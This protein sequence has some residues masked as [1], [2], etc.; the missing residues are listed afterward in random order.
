MPVIYTPFKD[1]RV[2]NLDSVLTFLQYAIANEFHHPDLP[3]EE[4]LS[5]YQLVLGF[6]KNMHPPCQIHEPDKYDLGEACLNYEYYDEYEWR[7][8]HTHRLQGEGRLVPVKT[9]KITADYY[10]RF[11][12]D[13]LEFIVV[14]DEE[15]QATATGI[16]DQIRYVTLH[17]YLL[18]SD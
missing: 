3:T 2:T 5:A 1:Y 14:P 6:L 12:P 10:L 15:A 8:C 7:I 4:L 17:E 16:N 11:Q 18:E 9:D 13:E